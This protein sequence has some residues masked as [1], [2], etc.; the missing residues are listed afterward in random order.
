MV[1]ISLLIPAWNESETI[2]ITTLENY[3]Y[4][5][6]LKKKSLISD[7]EII[8]LNDGSDDSTPE[9]LHKLAAEVLPLRIISNKQPTGIYQAFNLLYESATMD[10]VLLV[11]GDYQWRVEATK[12][13]CETF[14]DSGSQNAVSGIRVNRDSIYSNARLLVSKLLGRFADWILKTKNSDPGSIKILPNST[15]G[16]AFLSKSV[17][18]EIERLFLAKTITNNVVLQVAVPW[19]PR[20]SGVASGVSRKTLQPI[21]RDL[22]VLSLNKLRGNFSIKTLPVS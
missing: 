8:V 17:L 13:L 18:I 10:W 6:E 7:F 5:M 11:P 9:I 12:V 15:L 14:I 16:K 3:G 22:C 19:H 21:L 1:S 4:L 2:S 20:T